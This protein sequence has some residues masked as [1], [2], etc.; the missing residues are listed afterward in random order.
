MNAERR[1]NIKP[2]GGLAQRNVFQEEAKQ[3]TKPFIIDRWQVYE[4]YSLVK[5]NAG[6]VGMDKQSLADFE[7]NLKA[8]SLKFVAEWQTGYFCWGFYWFLKA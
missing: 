8:M 3:Q 6:S 7:V 2:S 5:A 1:A 4:A